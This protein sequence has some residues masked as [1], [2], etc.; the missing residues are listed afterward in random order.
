MAPAAKP[1]PLTVSVKAAPPAVAVLGLRE[2]IT[3]PEETVNVAAADVTPSS[4]TVTDSVPGVAMRLAVTWAV[5][6]VEFTKV[7]VSAVLFQWTTAP[8]RKPV[9]F[10]VRMKAGPLAV[11]AM[12]LREVITGSAATVKLAAPEVTPFSTTVTDAVPGVA[13]RLAV[14]WAVN[15]V[16]FTKVVLS[17][18]PFQSTTAPETKPMPFTV[19]V[20]ATPPAAAVLGLREVMAGPGAMVKVTP[21]EATP[22]SATVTV[23]EPAVVT[24]LAGTWAVNCVALTNVVV[25][26]VVPEVLVH[27]TV[28]PETK[29]EPLT[30]SAKPAWPAVALLGLSEVIAGPAAMVK[31]APLEVTPFTV[32]VTVAEPTVATRLAGT[33]AVNSVALPNVVVRDVVPEVLVHCTVAPET[34]PEPLTVSAKPAWP[35]IALLGLSEVIAGPAAMVKVAPLEVTPFT[36]T[37][38]VAEPTVAT[39]LAGTW[40]VNCVALPNVVVRDVVPEVLV[41]CTVAPETKPEP[42]TVSGKPA[43]PAI[44]L[45]GLSEVITGPGS[46]GEG[47]AGGCYPA[48]RHGDG[49]RA[50]RGNQGSRHRRRQLCGAH[51]SG[52]QPR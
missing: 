52:G 15:C 32:T 37:V 23:A 49:C 10:T 39:R 8:E 2:V 48:L 5:N 41:H 13:M 50:R 46:D 17:D 28:A 30:V 36:V 3:G 51:E 47:G 7:V 12:G 35:A 33:W 11:A 18:V 34:K 31:V 27:C 29:P 6:S 24:R 1:E 38:T 21:L 42:L 22:F 26:D 45:L 9:P 44:A 43:W 4:T 16:E 40:A 19:K 14:T 20:K 25:R